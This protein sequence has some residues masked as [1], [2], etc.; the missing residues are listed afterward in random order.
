MSRKEKQAERLAALEADLRSRLTTELEIVA[1]GRNTL[2]FETAEFNPHQLRQ[3]MLP[4][5]TEELSALASEALELSAALDYPDGAPVA[6]L[7]R[8]YLARANNLA[9]HHR[10]GSARLAREMLDELTRLEA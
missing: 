8:R 5:G 7:F 6:A 2:F 10:P 9:D 4:T 1:A 3:H